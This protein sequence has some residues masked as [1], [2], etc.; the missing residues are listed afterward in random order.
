MISN[1]TMK[2]ENLKNGLCPHCNGKLTKDLEI[3][4]TRCNFHIDTNKFNGIISH[5]GT[6]NKDHV[7][8]KWQNLH[9]N[10]C[11]ICS[12]EMF[13]NIKDDMDFHSCMNETCDFS[14]KDI[15]MMEILADKNHPANLFNKKL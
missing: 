8:I 9:E 2:W 7:K 4:C 10:K 6:E 15:R 3:R 14:I 12:Y 13:D 1:R 11:P 5:R